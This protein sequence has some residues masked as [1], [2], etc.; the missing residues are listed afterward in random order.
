MK[1][2]TDQDYSRQYKIENGMFV[3]TTAAKKPLD[4]RP[5]NLTGEH[6]TWIIDYYRK[7]ANAVLFEFWEALSEKPGGNSI[8]RIKWFPYPSYW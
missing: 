5:S 2:R 4:G 3:P 6:T 1:V 8:Y 7:N